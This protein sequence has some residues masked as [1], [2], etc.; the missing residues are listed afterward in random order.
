MNMF[1]VAILAGGLAT[2][3]QP[4]TKTIPKSLVLIHGKPFIHYQL[5]LLQQHGIDRVVIC[6]GFLGEQIE[7]YVGNGTAYQMDVQYA[8]DGA[9]LL[10]TGGALKKALP[11]L[12]EHFFVLYGDSFLVCDYSAVQAAFIAHKQPALM[13][14]FRN[15]GQWDSS[16]IEFAHGRI[17]AYDKVHRSSRMQFID[18]G[19]GIL[20]AQNFECVPDN[21][22]FDLAALYQ[23]LLK[24]A[25]LSAYEVKQ[26]FYEI[27]SFAGIKELEYYLSTK[28]LALADC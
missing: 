15:Q 21:I 22:P 5:Q 20:S 7:D 17:L 25:K 13:T 18:Y 14:V 19:L 11:L 23:I 28:K 10:G 24:D 6:A 27:G 16:N 2:R 8:Y 12:G 3:L 4:L 1:P 9:T 26:R